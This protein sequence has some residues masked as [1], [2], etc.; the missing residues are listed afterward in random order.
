[1]SFAHNVVLWVMQQWVYLVTEIDSPLLRSGS[2]L[3]L[4]YVFFRSHQQTL[5]GQERV[6]NP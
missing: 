6:T 3:L 2:L 1:M 4:V 5:V